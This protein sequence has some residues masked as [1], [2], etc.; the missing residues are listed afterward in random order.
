MPAAER[1]YDTDD[2]LRRQV[3]A[4]FSEGRLVPADGLSKSHR[5]TGRPCIVCR[6]VI[7]PTEVEREV[8]S[9][10]VFLHAHEVCY[11]VWREESKAWRSGEASAGCG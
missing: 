9:P 2:E 6:R 8:E 10:G 1:S 7:D 3:R 11:K 4:R 5:G